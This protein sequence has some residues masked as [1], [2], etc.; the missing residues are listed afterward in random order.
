MAKR[1]G[2]MNGKLQR[3]GVVEP[4]PAPETEE[5][6]FKPPTNIGGGLVCPLVLQQ[7]G[8]TYVFGGIDKLTLGALLIAAINPD[9]TLDGCATRSYDAIQA[10]HRMAVKIH[11]AT[12]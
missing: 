9:M 8:V 1:N 7:E 11:K 10:A 12:K 6:E 3:R 2:R 4:P 5:P